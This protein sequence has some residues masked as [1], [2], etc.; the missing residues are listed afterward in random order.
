MESGLSA[1]LRTLAP[2][3]SAQLG[4]LIVGTKLSS[5][6]TRSTSGTFS[7][8]PRFPGLSSEF[9]ITSM[10]W[11]RYWILPEVEKGAIDSAFALRRS[12]G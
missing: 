12:S 1:G 6:I 2:A 9:V 8:R 5:D 10:A 4:R 11:R 7:S 3:R